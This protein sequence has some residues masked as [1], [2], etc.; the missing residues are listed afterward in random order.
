MDGELPAH[1][2]EDFVQLGRFPL[3]LHS[4]ARGRSRSEAAKALCA[5]TARRP[6]HRATHA[7]CAAGSFSTEPAFGVA[8]GG[9][10]QL[11]LGLAGRPPQAARRL[12]A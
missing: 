2:S 5:A 6:D 3:T 1:V 9:L 11:G 7:D 4:P 10:P 12:L 8:C